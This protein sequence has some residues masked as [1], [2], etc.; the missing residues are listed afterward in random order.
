M[1]SMNSLNVMVYLWK[2]Q[3]EIKGVRRNLK[4]YV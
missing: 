2:R 3:A 4:I 1:R